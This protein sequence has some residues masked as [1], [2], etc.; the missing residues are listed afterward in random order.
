[1]AN[2]IGQC[3]A[4]WGLQRRPWRS[5]VRDVFDEVREFGNDPG[6]DEFHDVLWTL[7]RFGLDVL[8]WNWLPVS[9]YCWAKYETRFQAWRLSH[10]T[11]CRC[12]IRSLC[13]GGASSASNPATPSAPQQNATLI[14]S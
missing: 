10:A 6:K 12:Q 13:K 1:M 4:R 9:N 3:A 2:R 8:G 5:S 11:G 7:A 14:G